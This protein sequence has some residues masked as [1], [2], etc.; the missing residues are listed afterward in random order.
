MMHEAISFLNEIGNDYGTLDESERITMGL[1]YHRICVVCGEEFSTTSSAE[2]MCLHC[3]AVSDSS[4]V[5]PIRADEFIRG[6]EVHDLF[7]GEKHLKT[8]E[9]LTQQD[10]ALAL[11]GRHVGRHGRSVVNADIKYKKCKR[12]ITQ[13]RICCV[14]KNKFTAVQFHQ[15]QCDEC[16]KLDRKMEAKMARNLAEKPCARCGK[17]FQPRGGHSLYCQECVAESAHNKN[18]PDQ[19]PKTPAPV[20]LQAQS[21]DTAVLELLIRCRRITIEQVNAARTLING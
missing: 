11:G 18:K 1:Q 16:L 17:P 15:R 3:R 7:D 13:E 10:A 8:G 9:I 12:F 19:G 4:A 2:S 14:C 6:G 5:S 20:I 21:S